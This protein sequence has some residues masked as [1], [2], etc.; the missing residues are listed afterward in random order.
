MI[1]A[2]RKCFFNIELNV[3]KLVRITTQFK[4]N[5]NNHKCDDEFQNFANVL[6]IY[7]QLRP[8]RVTATDQINDKKL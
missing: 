1:L 8:K 5:F 2:A 3:L 7:S 6:Q 4:F